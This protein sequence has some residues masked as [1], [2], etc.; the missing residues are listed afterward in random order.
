MKNE[1]YLRGIKMIGI[2]ITMTFSI[3]RLFFSFEKSLGDVLGAHV[4]E[5]QN[6]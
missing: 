6:M 1:L 3:S 4:C 2:R 5:N